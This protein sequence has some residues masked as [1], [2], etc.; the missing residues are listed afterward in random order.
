[1]PI[2]PHLPEELARIVGVGGQGAIQSESERSCQ[3]LF[4]FGRAD[5]GRSGTS[6][7]HRTV[8]GINYRMGQSASSGKRRAR[9]CSLKGNLT[10]SSAPHHQGLCWAT[11]RHCTKGARS[12]PIVQETAV[13][14]QCSQRSSARAQFTM[15]IDDTAARLRGASSRTCSKE[16]SA[17]K[18]TRSTMPAA[19]PTPTA[20]SASPD[21]APR[22]ARPLLTSS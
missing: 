8:R 3:E 20:A 12:A 22:Q 7:H 9:V 17:E 21:D 19:P 2:G 5:G 15:V 16:S 18:S 1:M 6:P 10:T 4:E 11:S 13:S 14:T